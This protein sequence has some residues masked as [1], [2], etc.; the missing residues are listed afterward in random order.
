[1]L[2]PSSRLF[3]NHYAL[4]KFVCVVRYEMSLRLTILQSFRVVSKY[5]GMV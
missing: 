4:M 1:L 5:C 2:S 3:S